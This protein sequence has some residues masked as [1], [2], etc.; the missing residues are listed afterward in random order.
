MLI[1]EEKSTILRVGKNASRGT[2]SPLTSINMGGWGA[3]ATAGIQT[4]LL[5][6]GAIQWIQILDGTTVM[7]GNVKLVIL[8]R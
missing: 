3:T 6:S 2:L 8:V 4:G 1:I 5:V 7:L